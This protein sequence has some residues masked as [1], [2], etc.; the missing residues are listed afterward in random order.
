M[1]RNRDKLFSSSMIANR[2]KLIRALIPALALPWVAQAA[3]I[4]TWTY[5]GNSGAGGLDPAKYGGNYTPN[6]LL[7]DVGSTGDGHI[8][9]FNFISG[10]VG[11]SGYPDGYGGYLTLFSSSISLQYQTTTILSE[12]DSITLSF[13]VGGGANGYVPSPITYSN[14]SITLNY[15]GG[16]QAL[17][18]S[19]FRSVSAGIEPTPV[20]GDQEMTIYTWTWNGIS[21]LDPL[22]DFSFSW[23]TGGKNFVFFNEI[24]VAQIPEP[25][26]VVLIFAGSLVL[27]LSHRRRALPSQ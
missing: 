20:M 6:P 24:S 4:D 10:G 2:L 22:T 8:S 18:S 5:Q 23:N 16:N 26:A 15:N 7:P 1:R 12:L 19:S 13:K 25:T 9:I 11:S 3:L 17:E 27:L 21:L 14:N